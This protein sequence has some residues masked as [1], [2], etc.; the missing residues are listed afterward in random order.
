MCPLG[1]PAARVLSQ[2]ALPEAPVIINA[3]LISAF[4]AP[5]QK[6]GNGLCPSAGNEKLI[7]VGFCAT[8]AL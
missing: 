4:P 8:L 6:L 2:R 5:L 1:R 7:K 3:Y